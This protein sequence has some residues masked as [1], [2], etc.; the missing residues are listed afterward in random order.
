RCAWMARRTVALRGIVEERETVQLLLRQ[1]R[2]ATLPVVVLARERMKLFVLSLEGGDRLTHALQSRLRII[3]YGAAVQR[4]EICKIGARAQPRDHRGGIVVRHLQ[5][6]GEGRNGLVGERRGAAV[7][8]EAAVGSAVGVEIE[9]RRERH[10]D[11]RR[12]VAKPGRV[13]ER[14]AGSD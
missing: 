5:R 4:F 9:F 13:A 7:T 14:S 11:Q 12:R 3:E 8:K 2:L 10:I 6:V 1:S